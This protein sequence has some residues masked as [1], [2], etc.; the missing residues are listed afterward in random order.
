MLKRHSARSEDCGSSVAG[1]QSWITLILLLASPLYPAPLLAE[2]AS[3]ALVSQEIIYHSPMAGEVL[4]IWGI[5]G[6]QLVPEEQRPIG[7]TGSSKVM[8]SPMIRQGANFKIKILVPSGATLNYGFYTNRVRDGSWAGIYD[9]G[10]QSG[11]WAVVPQPAFI[12]IHASRQTTDQL[13]N[14]EIKALVLGAKFAAATGI[15]FGAFLLLP[16]IL[17]RWCGNLR[18][19]EPALAFLRQ[20]RVACILAGSLV[21]YV[22]AINTDLYLWEDN[23]RY[24]IAGKSIASGQGLHQIHD[25]NNPPYPYPNPMFPLM[26][27]PIV[28]LFGY[29]LWPMKFAVVLLAI[30]ALYL[31]YRLFRDSLSESDSTLLLLFVAVSPQIVSFSH[32]IMTEIPYMVWSCLALLGARRYAKESHT[33][34]VMGLLTAAAITGTILTKSIGLAVISA[35]ALSFFHAPLSFSQILKRVAFL[36][37][38]SGMAWFLSNYSILRVMPYNNEC[39][40]SLGG[41]SQTLSEMIHHFIHRIATNVSEYAQHLPETLLYMTSHSPS[42]VWVSLVCLVAGSGYLWALFNRRSI[43]EY[44]VA[45][46][47]GILLVYDLFNLGNTQRYLVPLTP[48]IVYY[49]MCG[50][51]ELLPRLVHPNAAVSSVSHRS[52]FGSGDALTRGWVRSLALAVI[53]SLIIFNGV[54]TVRASVL[55]KDPEMFDY[56]GLNNGYRAHRAMAFWVKQHT[57]PASV[58]MTRRPDLFHVWSLRRIE[59][60]PYVSPQASRDDVLH[61]LLSARADF[62]ALD[63]LDLELTGQDRRLNEVIRQSPGLFPIVYQDGDTSLVRVSRDSFQRPEAVRGGR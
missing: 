2:T 52:E 25:V 54:S 50:L 59:R 49:S 10:G 43:I 27:A 37:S 41:P 5:N 9:A 23:A 46:Y 40:S 33:L 58:I 30:A 29:Q 31:S 15:L 11:Y 4:L 39:A 51:N 26:L 53:S 28:A 48:M 38:A 24:I 20:N 55:K 61:A 32:Q 13:G 17:S 57:D 62:I 36:C 18:L 60:H 14:I 45:F 8:Q 7:T 22:I 19:L 35:A 63:T 3:A 16:R 47:M 42:A 21:V 1:W 56:Y 44:Y 34:T 12:E 6:W